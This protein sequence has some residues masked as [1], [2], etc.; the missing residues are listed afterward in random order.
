M[1]L[2]PLLVVITGNYPFEANHGEVPFIRPELP[3]LAGAFPRIVVAP[4]RPFGPNLDPAA[5]AQ[6]DTSL[7]QRLGQSRVVR[8]L[9]ALCGANLWSELP[10]A[11]G[12]AGRRGVWRALVWSSVAEVARRWAAQRF[13]GEQS[14][15]FYTYWRTGATTGLAQASRGRPGWAA[16]TRVHGNDLYLERH[17]PPYQPYCPSLYRQVSRTYAISQAG[18]NYILSLG[19]EAERLRIARLGIEDPCT[20]CRASEDGILRLVS[21]SFLVSVKRV[22]LLARGIVEYARQR[23]SL[24]LEWTHIGDGEERNRVLSELAGSPPNLK[25]SMLGQLQNSDVLNYYGSNRV[26]LFLSASASEGLPVSMMEAS[27]VG[28]PILATDVGGVGEIVLSENGT[29]LPPHPSVDDIINGLEWYRN[30]PA[31]KRLALRKAARQVWERSYSAETNHTRFA[32]D[33]VQCWN[34]VQ[35]R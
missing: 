8:A 1:S 28:V 22:P 12:R 4:L 23:P 5:P 31:E 27:A 15:L 14:V 3:R 35:T 33:L 9:G 17:S 20:N 19:I 7:A 13:A 26:D 30:L 24:R 10:E 11:F 34:S 16:V 29:L 18:M 21:C 32:Q 6:I 2:I 25:V